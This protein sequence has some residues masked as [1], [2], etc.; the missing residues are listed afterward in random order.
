MCSCFPSLVNLYT[1]FTSNHNGTVFLNPDKGNY[2]NCSSRGQFR[3]AITSRPYS[4]REVATPRK[5]VTS[6]AVPTLA[7]IVLPVM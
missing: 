1:I 7:V 3:D 6:C 5:F 2:I 4:E